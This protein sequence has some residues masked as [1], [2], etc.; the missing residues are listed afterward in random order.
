MSNIAGSDRYH[1][2]ALNPEQQATLRYLLLNYLNLKLLSCLRRIQDSDEDENM[3][4]TSRLMVEYTR[5]YDSMVADLGHT[6]N[7]SKRKIATYLFTP[8]N[9]LAV[10]AGVRH[11][12][13]FIAKRATDEKE[14]LTISRNIN[15]LT[16]IANQAAM[17][18]Y[19]YTE[20][21]DER[22]RK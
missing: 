22:N 14:F 5:Q 19:S 20:I 7:I 17:F 18:T 8:E 16:D 3:L 13:E 12:D 21:R 6:H 11:Y 2:I 15:K 10:K 1:V 9:M 4:Q